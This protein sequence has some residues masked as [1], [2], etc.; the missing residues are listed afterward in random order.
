M[1]AREEDILTSQNLI[2][3]GV[4][5]EKL[6]ESVIVTPGVKI[7]DLLI[8]DKNAIFIACRRLAYG[9]NYG[10]VEVT[11]PKCSEANKTTIDLSG[12]KNKE[13]DFSV[14]QRGVNLF[15]CVLPFT[16]RNVKY[17]LLTHKDEGE[18]ET[19]LT[20]LNKIKGGS[21]HE[22]TTRLKKMI[23]AIDGNEDRALIN[24]FVDNQ[25][26]A[27]DSQLFRKIIRDNIPD[28][29]SSFDF[30]CESCGHGERMGIPITVSFFWPES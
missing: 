10:P 27:R 13:Y 28:V 15:E 23:V 26:V 16:K 19:E 18:I 8:G 14:H 21:S 9:D 6:L 11:C 20:S 3:K 4:V 25:L 2:K 7:N 12:V 1:T 22:I 5:L 30:V 29:D 24:K 17:R